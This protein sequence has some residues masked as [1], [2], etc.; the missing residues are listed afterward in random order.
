MEFRTNVIRTSVVRT[1]VSVPY[2][3]HMLFMGHKKAAIPEIHLVLEMNPQAFIG[4][5]RCVFG[6]S[7]GIT[8]CPPEIAHCTVTGTGYD[9]TL[10]RNWV[11]IMGDEGG[12]FKTPKKDYVIYEQP[13]TV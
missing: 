6:R 11:K 4:P 13:L 2:F 7:G 1:N 3:G 8:S 5:K 12:G 10:T 9:S